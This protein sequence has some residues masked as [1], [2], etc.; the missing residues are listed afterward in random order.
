MPI[1]LSLSPSKGMLDC[2]MQRDLMQW[3]QPVAS[4]HRSPAPR[5]VVATPL[6]A[7]AHL[8]R[9][10]TVVSVAV[11]SAASVP[12]SPAKGAAPNG[13][14]AHHQQQPAASSSGGVKAV[15]PTFS[16]TLLLQCT[17]QKGVIAAVSQLLYGLNCNIVSSDQYRYRLAGCSRFAKGPCG[18]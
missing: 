9:A 5:T 13:G 8:Q 12:S 17:D 4:V 11:P 6:L 14:G 7:A 3:R 16:A 15:Q 1:S 18:K 2:L 10:A